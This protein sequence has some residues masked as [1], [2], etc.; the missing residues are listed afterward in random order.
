MSLWNA[1]GSRCRPPPPPSPGFRGD[2]LEP[3]VINI[4]PGAGGRVPPP[5]GGLKKRLHGE[6]CIQE[7]LLVP[8]VLLRVPGAPQHIDAPVP[9]GPSLAKHNLSIKK[10]VNSDRFNSMSAAGAPAVHPGTL[11]VGLLQLP[12]DSADRLIK[13]ETR[14]PSSPRESCPS[15][16]GS[17]GGSLSAVAPLATCSRQHFQACVGLESPRGAATQ[18]LCLVCGDV[19]SGYHYGVASC[20]ACKAFFKRTIQGNIDYA[21]PA[22]KQ[23][24]ITQRRRKSCQFCRFAKC[25][26]VGMLKE[27]VRLDRV[28]GGRQKYRRCRE[29]DG[30]GF[31]GETLPDT[32]KPRGYP[33]AVTRIVSHLLTAE[34]GRIYATPDP[35]APDSELNALAT[36]CDLTDRELVLTIGWAKNIPGFSSLSLGDQMNLLQGAWMEMLLLG[37]AFRSLPFHNQLV[38]ADDYIM[39]DTRSRVS[40]LQDLFLVTLPLVQRYR[41]LRMDKEEY[42]TL[43]ALALANSDSALIQDVQS[44]Q[45]LQDHLQEALQDYETLQHRDEPARAGQ[46]LLTLPLLRQTS[47]RAVQYFL[48]VRAEGRVPI[49]RLLHEMLEAKA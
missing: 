44:V 45:S 48:G 30:G 10:M 37:V 33:E 12:C 11:E 13:R 17:S 19:A 25:L 42:V 8:S 26:R 38:Y 1:A 31:Q 23:C 27:G 43:K 47:M 2:A 41:K 14:S 29:A 3:P 7:S 28:R 49:H 18:R 4:R 36:L 16:G 34:P 5:F 9:G 46:L 40:G 22:A 15:P 21:C 35:A 20:E 32:L 39:D 6:L 24:D